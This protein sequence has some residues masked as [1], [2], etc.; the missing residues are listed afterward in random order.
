M[1]RPDAG[2]AVGL[3]LRPYRASLRAGPAGAAAQAAE[4]VLDV[5]PVLV[6]QH[7]GLREG[8]A[9]RPEARAQLVEEAEVDVDLRVDRAVE[10]ADV[11]GRRP[12]AALCR[13]VE[14]HRLRDRVVATVGAELPGPVVLD[15]VH[16]ADDAAVLARVG[17]D[18]GSAVRRDGVRRLGPDRAVVEV[19]ERA[20]ETTAVREHRD[21][22][23]DDDADPE[24]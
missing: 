18:G 7:V 16:V 4:Q 5:V 23:V 20:G 1:V 19:R 3:Q 21:Q 9:R 2:Q 12:A 13:A 11:R 17:I 22:Q 14:E 6:R 15:A 24:E 10:R 8:T